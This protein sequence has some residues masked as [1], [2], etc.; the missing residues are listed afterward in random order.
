MQMASN[1]WFLRP[2]GYDMPKLLFCFPMAGA[3]ASMYRNWP[4]SIGDY[5]ICSIQL[6]GRETRIGDYLPETIL[7]FAAEFASDLAALVDRPF[8]FFGHC[9]GARLAY[10]SA[11]QLAKSHDLELGRLIVSAAASP[12]DG[13]YGPIPQSLREQAISAEIR[14]AMAS[15]G[16][17]NPSAELMV[18]AGQTLAMDLAWFIASLNEEANLKGI[19]ITAIDWNGDPSVSRA[20]MLGWEDFG[21][22]DAYTLDGDHYSVTDA[23]HELIDIVEGASRCGILQHGGSSKGETRIESAFAMSEESA[24]L[25]LS[26]N[27]SDVVEKDVIAA[28]LKALPVHQIAFSDE[29]FD[30]GGNSLIAARLARQLSA[31][32]NVKVEIAVFRDQT[33]PRQ[34]AQLIRERLIG[35]EQTQ[36]AGVLSGDE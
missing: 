26:T 25:A 19:P 31:K 8:D 33:T 16:E 15:A 13:Y 21:E 20:N 4:R 30:C 14:R 18:L 36:F 29:F 24:A 9:L 34:I 22:V 2:I 11:I 17:H 1:K 5:E 32:F 12:G 10:A 35:K 6:P 7:D 23:P 27:T 28:W 3:G